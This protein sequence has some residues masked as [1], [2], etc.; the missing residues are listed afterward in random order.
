MQSSSAAQGQRDREEG[1]GGQA[2]TRSDERASGQRAKEEFPEAPDGPVLG[3]ND[4]RGG[5]SCVFVCLGVC[6]GGDGRSGVWG[7]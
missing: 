4:E 2:A 7:K 6:K 3:M 1:K 5:V